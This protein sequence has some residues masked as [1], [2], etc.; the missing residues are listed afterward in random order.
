M[1][2]LDGI[3]AFYGK[4]HVLHSVSMH[5][6]EG[7]VVCLVG[8]NGAGKSTALKSI[9]GLV[10]PRDGAIT[11]GAERLDGLPPF[12]VARRGVGYVPEERRVFSGLTVAENLSLPAMGKAAWTLDDVFDRFPSLARRRRNY[13][14]QLSGGEQQM[15]AI[16]R[17]LMFEPRVLLL[18]EPSQGLAPAVVESVMEML[19]GLSRKGQS[20]LLVEQNVEMALALGQRH[21]VIDQG[22]IV[23]EGTTA[24][25]R[26]DTAVWERYVGVGEAPLSA[27]E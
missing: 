16:A 25:M 9:M 1:L 22:E 12:E 27:W 10:V 17:V 18:D 2:R 19:H 13:G 26:A 7:E 5:V 24:Q 21:Y 8:R 20:I 4:A 11:L 15:V 3:Q 14:N 6:D 23:F